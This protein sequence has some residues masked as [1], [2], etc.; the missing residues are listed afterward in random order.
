M[1][2]SSL[3]AST[4]GTLSTA[5]MMSALSTATTTASSGVAIRTPLLRVTIFW[6]SYWSDTG[7]TLRSSRTGTDLPGSTSGSPSPRASL[8]AV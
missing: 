2:R 5:N 8:I 1:N 6:P 4:A 7:M 3:T